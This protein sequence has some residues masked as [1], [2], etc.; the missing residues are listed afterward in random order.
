MTR[1]SASTTI[2]SGA[3]ASPNPVFRAAASP[4]GAYGHRR[5]DPADPIDQEKEHVALLL[6]AEAEKLLPELAEMQ[7][8]S[9][10][11]FKA[12]RD[13]KPIK[14][15][16]GDED[17]V[18]HAMN[19]DYQ[20]VR[21]GFDDF[22]AQSCNHVASLNAPALGSLARFEGMAGLG[23]KRRCR[24]DAPFQGWSCKCLRIACQSQEP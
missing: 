1:L 6:A 12:F 2:T 20:P 21:I 8:S 13:I 18:A 11:H 24:W 22:A 16:E 7:V 9:Q 17:F 5:P 3:R 15:R 23:G 19:I 10:I 4:A 14:R